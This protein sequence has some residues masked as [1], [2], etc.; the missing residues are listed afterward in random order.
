MKD[1]P[2]FRAELSQHADDVAVVTVE[3][4]VDL[5]TA[6]EFKEVLLGAVDEGARHVIVDLSAVT[7][8][9]STALGVLVVAGRR[10]TDAGGE[11]RL[12]GLRP[13]VRKV[14]DITGLSGA[15]PI[16]PDLATATPLSGV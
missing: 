15:F 1:R 10:C 5:Y 16:L 3:G 8:V 13:H 2:Q 9:D 4:E 7:F 12:V 11:L 14:F 6:P